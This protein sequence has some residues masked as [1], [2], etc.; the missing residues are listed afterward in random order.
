MTKHQSFF[1]S[2]GFTLAMSLLAIVMIVN[3]T[4]LVLDGV[5][6][7]RI[8]GLIAWI[9]MAGY[10]FSTFLARRRERRRSPRG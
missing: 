9:M 3:Y 10:F 5:T 4:G 6:P 8:F 1:T 7:L 2:F